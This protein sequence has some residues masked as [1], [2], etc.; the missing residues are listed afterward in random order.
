MSVKDD[1]SLPD[2]KERLKKNLSCADIHS[3]LDYFIF[4]SLNPICFKSYYSR[5]YISD[6]IAQI[7]TNNNRKISSLEK[8]KFVELLFTCLVTPSQKTYWKIFKKLRLERNLFDKIA[9]DFLNDTKD[10]PGLEIA[11]IKG[12]NTVLTRMNYIEKHVGI[13]RN[14]LSSTINWVHYFLEKYFDFKGMI[15]EKY[16]RYAYIDTM[17]SAKTTSLHIDR[18]DLFKN[19]ILAIPRAIDKHDPTKGTL[20]SYIQIWMKHSK[21]NPT[22]NHVLNQ[23]YDINIV[24]RKGIT[25]ARNAGNSFENNLAHSLDSIEAQ[26]KPDDSN[27]EEF[28]IKKDNNN[29]LSKLISRVKNSK[30]S[31]LYYDIKYVLTEEEL[32]LLKKSSIQYNVDYTYCIEHE[33]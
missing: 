6:M 7:Y 12:D 27:I 31:M 24:Q 14:I 25:A 21:I 29:I 9:Q 19:L 30:M 3:T 32:E 1:H 15:I 5:R 10:Y 13:G 20:T 8:S 16:V 4:N 23:S 22:F 28:I 33:M 11:Y 2:L 26:E 17:K 18:Q